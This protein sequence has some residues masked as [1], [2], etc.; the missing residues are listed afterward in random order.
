MAQMRPAIHTESSVIFKV[1]QFRWWSHL[2][3][4]LIIELDLYFTSQLGALTCHTDTEWVIPGQ[5]RPRLELQLSKC[6]LEECRQPSVSS[7]I[8]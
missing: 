7:S 6:M 1:Y 5:P 4:V 3:S 8:I 2:G